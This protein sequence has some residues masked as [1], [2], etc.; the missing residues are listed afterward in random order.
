MK[1]RCK[2]KK[3]VFADCVR[4]GLDNPVVRDVVYTPKELY[5][6]SSQGMAINLPNNDKLYYDG[7][8]KATFDMLPESKRGVDVSD[9]WQLQQ[10]SRKR[11]SQAYRNKKMNISNL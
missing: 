11:I 6:L 8:D 9:L 5:D 1:L 10:A 7:D 4:T 2:V 3:Q